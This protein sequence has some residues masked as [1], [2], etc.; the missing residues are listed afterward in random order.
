MLV[1]NRHKEQSIV[2]GGD[3]EVKICD[4]R[5]DIVTLGI[6]AP[7]HISVHRKEIQDAINRETKVL[8][9]IGSES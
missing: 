9:G 1:L 6:E 2:I 7:K 4:I 3:I 8:A 5:G